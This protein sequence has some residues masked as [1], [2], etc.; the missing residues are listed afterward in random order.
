[1]ALDSPGEVTF[2]FDAHPREAWSSNARFKV[3]GSEVE[4]ELQA[5]VQQDSIVGILARVPLLATKHRLTWEWQYVLPGTEEEG[6]VKSTPSL[7]L[8]NITVSPVPDAGASECVACPQGSEVSAKFH[9]CTSCRPGESTWD[10]NETWSDVGSN[11]LAPGFRC[12]PC[13][14]GFYAPTRGS[15]H[16]LP[17]GQGT[18][19]DRG[20]TNCKPGLTVVKPDPWGGKDDIVFNVSGLHHVWQRATV[21]QTLQAEALERAGPFAVSDN[22][23]FIS[24]FDRVSA[25]PSSSVEAYIWEVVPRSVTAASVGADECSKTPGTQDDRLVRSVGT[26]LLSLVPIVSEDFVGIQADYGQGSECAGLGRKRRS[27]VLFRCDA[28]ELEPSGTRRDR[29]GTLHLPGLVAP[30]PIERPGLGGCKKVVFEWPSAGACPLCRLSDFVPIVG[31]C[32]TEGYQRITYSQPSYCVGG[33][34]RPEEKDEPCKDISVALA[35]ALL[36]SALCFVGLCCYAACLHLKYAKL[37]AR[38]RG[39]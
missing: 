38:D 14:I 33:V 28:R 6:D 24:P 31:E 17:C 21:S 39:L 18:L 20:A 1:V 13:P 35:P 11:V 8:R 10:L 37:A 27:T 3:D 29:A 25:E 19:S 22:R 7:R 23:Y 30:S 34:V 12:K 2:V 4:S 9:R 16:C 5:V 36:A 32:R 15:P 26:T